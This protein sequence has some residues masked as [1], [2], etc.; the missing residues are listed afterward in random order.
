MEI[1]TNHLFLKRQEKKRTTPIIIMEINPFSLTESGFTL[2]L[3]FRT[4]LP[5][6]TT[7]NISNLLLLFQAEQLN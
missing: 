3:G 4:I 2:G 1:M 5:N 6:S 7:E